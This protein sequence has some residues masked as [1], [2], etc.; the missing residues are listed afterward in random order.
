MVGSVVSHYRI[1]E[2]LGEGGMGVVYKAEDTKLRRTVALKFLPP[3]LTRDPDAK[4]RF[5]HEARAAAALNHANIVTVYEINE[6]EDRTYIAMEHV[7][8]RSLKDII[9]G[10]P[11]PATLKLMQISQA[12][13]FAIQI[14]RGLAAAHAMGIVHRDIKPAN[15]FITRDNTVK[16]LDFGIA[17]LA[18][19]ETKLTRTGSTVGTVAYMSPEQAMGK[20]VDR[21][22]DIWSLGVLLYEMLSGKTPFRGEYPQAIVYSILNEE[23]EPLTRVRPDIPPGLEQII[24]LAL[25]KD[26]AKRYQ[27]ME[28]FVGDLK[29][30]AEGLKPLT[31]KPKPVRRKYFG[32][33]KIYLACGLVVAAAVLVGL[34]IGGVRNLFLKKAGASVIHSLA[35][36]P[37]ANL[38][39]DPAQEYFSDG[40]TEELIATL[41][42]ISTLKV[43]SR[44]SV[45][46]F[47]GSRKPLREIAAKLGVDG[48]IEGSVLRSGERV[49]ITAQLIDA[50]SDTH[51]WAESYERDLRDVL[52]VQ[53]EVAQDIAR[54]IKANLTPQEQARLANVRTV[55]PEAYDAYLKGLQLWYKL[56]PADMDGAQ[57]YFELAL[58]KEPAYAAAYAGIALVWGGRQQMGWTPPSEAAP[59]A[60]AAALKAVELDDTVAE[61]HYALAIIKAWTDWDW[62]GAKSEFQRA[63]KLNPGFPDARIYYSHLLIALG[64]VQEA[65]EQG[66][67]AIELDPYNAL[68]HGLFGVTL[69]MAHRYD[70]ALFQARLALKTNPNDVI[71]LFALW[72]SYEKKQMYKEAVAAAEAVYKASYNLDNSEAL[73]RGFAEGGFQTAMKRGTKVLEAYS[74][75]NF[76]LP[77]DMAMLLSSAGD[78]RSALDWLEKGYEIHDPGMPYLGLP[79]YDPLRSDPRF[80]DLVRRMKL[81]TSE[82]K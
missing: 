2:K 58:Q 22:A 38:S 41:S 10:G 57:Q 68:F 72:T 19:S 16:I 51:L 12:L 47:K 24:G 18:V 78:N 46:L 27:A 65:I 14:A 75:K 11:S 17:K 50:A 28:E 9:S 60:R 13:D 20:E 43:I 52:A 23:P 25:A 54:E 63:I 82:K 80:Q 79:S 29:A 73:D 36:L 40:M 5:L 56:T 62:A 7:E 21:R 44:T 61:A 53:S 45:M 8:G 4:Q 49:R 70:D 32:W 3:E 39:G 55:N 31:A 34:N 35:V 33:R 77:T 1:L 42:K 71:G 66:K 81:P 67:R 37:L 59:K 6:H 26:P 76:V 15:I 64:R 48:V 69:A 30:V 74:Q